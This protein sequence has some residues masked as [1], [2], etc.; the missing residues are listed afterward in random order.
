MVTLKGIMHLLQSLF[1][2]TMKVRAP[3][4]QKILGAIEGPELPLLGMVISFYFLIIFYRTIYWDLLIYSFWLFIETLSW[5]F[6]ILRFFGDFFIGTSLFELC[7]ESF[8][9]DSLWI[10]LY[11]DFSYCGIYIGPI[12]NT[13]VRTFYTYILYWT[14]H[15]Y[16]F[17]GL[18]SW[19]GFIL[20]LFVFTVSIFGCFCWDRV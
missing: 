10:L 5:N 20:P 16:Y 12:I 7:M 9:W 6:S 19:M 2:Q 15:Q 14:Y 13:V 8:Y 11:R 18:F 4:N 1:S 3:S 17:L